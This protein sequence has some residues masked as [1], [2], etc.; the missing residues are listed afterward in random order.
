MRTD[1]G[2]ACVGQATRELTVQRQLSPTQKREKFRELL[3]RPDILVMPD[4][5]Q[6][7]YG[8]TF[9]HPTLT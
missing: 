8:T 5:Q 4:E 3:G 9:G 7:D 6:R 2:E 1:E